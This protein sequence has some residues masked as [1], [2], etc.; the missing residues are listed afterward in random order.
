[1]KA[2]YRSLAIPSGFLAL[3]LGCA[4]FANAAGPAQGETSGPAAGTHTT[5]STSVQK[6]GSDQNGSTSAGRPGTTGK[7][8]AES[9]EKP[10]GSSATGQSNSR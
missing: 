7:Q 8:G 9:G 2:S 4:P 3:A 10:K 6:Q 5:P 1:M